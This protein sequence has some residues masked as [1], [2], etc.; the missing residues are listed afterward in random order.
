MGEKEKEKR[1]GGRVLRR[2]GEGEERREELRY[3]RASLYAY[4]PI[5]SYQNVEFIHVRTR[6]ESNTAV[7]IYVLYRIISTVALIRS[8][9]N[10]LHILHNVL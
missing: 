10:L 8:M 5:Q 7:L 9:K 1:R 2:G 6:P 3:N 4:R